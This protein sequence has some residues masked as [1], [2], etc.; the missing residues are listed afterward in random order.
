LITVKN[1]Q[2]ELSFDK[3]QFTPNLETVSL[4][5]TKLSNVWGKEV[6][7]LTLTAKVLIENGEYKFIIRKL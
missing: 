1:E 4:T 5:D 6:Y 3:N 2:L 7:R